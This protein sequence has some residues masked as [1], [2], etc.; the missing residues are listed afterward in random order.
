VSGAGSFGDLVVELGALI[1][2]V[3]GAIVRVAG[4]ILREKERFD[5]RV[6]ARIDRERRTYTAAGQAAYEASKRA[7]Q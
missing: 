3:P 5:S 1:G 4:A 6:A 2:G 7:G